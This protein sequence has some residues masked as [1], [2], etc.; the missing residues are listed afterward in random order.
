MTSAVRLWNS[1]LKM[2]PVLLL[3]KKGDQNSDVNEDE[4]FTEAN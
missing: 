4:L 3:A 2:N 1:D